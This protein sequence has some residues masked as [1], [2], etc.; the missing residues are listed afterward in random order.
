[1]RGV[2]SSDENETRKRGAKKR[3]KDTPHSRILKQAVSFL[4]LFP[5]KRGCKRT[6]RENDHAKKKSDLPV[7]K[8]QLRIFHAEPSRESAQ[9]YPE[10]SSRKNEHPE[11]SSEPKGPCKRVDKQRRQDMI[12][13]L[14]T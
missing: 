13:Q 6:G 9:K 7:I 1:M 3:I 10:D 2:V 4:S 11:S 8:M 12:L 5:H 14:R